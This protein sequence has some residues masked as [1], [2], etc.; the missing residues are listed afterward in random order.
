MRRLIRSVIKIIV[1]GLVVFLATQY[2]EGIHIESLDAAVFL[3]FLLAVLNIFVRPILVLV[4]L[5]ISILTLGLFSFVINMVLFWF[6]G[7]F[8]DGVEIDGFIPALLGSLVVSIVSWVFDVLFRK[9]K[10]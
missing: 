6:A 9:K 4:T 2:I 10:K 7:T 1:V 5:P 3:S 8:V